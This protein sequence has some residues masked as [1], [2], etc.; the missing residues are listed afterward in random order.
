L[1]NDLGL[2]RDEI[3]KARIVFSKIIIRRLL[4]GRA[5]NAGAVGASTDD[6]STLSSLG[7]VVW[8]M[9]A[10][11]DALP[12]GWSGPTEGFS[13]IGYYVGDGQ[14]KYVDHQQDTRASG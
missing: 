7:R 13:H 10:A 3:Q 2:Y 5:T 12:L 8:T 1:G 11:A 4:P 9:G 6:V 14:Y